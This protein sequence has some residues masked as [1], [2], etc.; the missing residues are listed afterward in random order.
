MAGVSDTVEVLTELLERETIHADARVLPGGK[1]AV[2]QVSYALN[3]EDAEIWAIDLDTREREFLTAGSTPRYASTGHLLFATPDGALMA[4]SIDPGS[5]EFTTTAVSIAEGLALDPEFGVV[6]YGVSEDGTLAYSAGDD[7]EGSV[8]LVWVTRS[9]V[10][11]PV[12]PGWRFDP[13]GAGAR[14]SLS[15]DGSRVA[16]TRLLDG[17]VDIWI[18]QLPDGPVERLTFDDQDD[19][20]PVWTPDGQFVRYVRNESGGNY[21]V[22]QRRADH[23]GTPE[24]LLDD[25]LSLYDGRGS[26]DGEWMVFRTTVPQARIGERDIV[27]F[28]PGV[29]SVV[30]PLIANAEFVEQSPALSPD[31][32]WL[33][34]T[35]DETGRQEV[36][37]TSF[38]N[39]DSGEARVSTEGGSVPLWGNSGG[40]LFFV[41]GDRRLVVAQVDADSAFRVLQRETLFGLGP[42]YGLSGGIAYDVAPDDQRFL[43][44]RSTLTAAGEASAGGTRFILVYNWFEEFRERVRN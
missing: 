27:A 19:R 44:A 4:A 31:G 36:Y 34:Y 9:G 1:T 32:R 5:A 7:S 24:L 28:R 12:D 30:I 13:S 15:P 43:L 42:E 11:T 29:D 26:S 38:P 35:S 25:E 41:D 22:W 6:F 3:G 20:Y 21:D 2:F 40:E 8:E 37:V 39:V 33:A 18:K 17:N 10:A 14:W 16:L 23:T